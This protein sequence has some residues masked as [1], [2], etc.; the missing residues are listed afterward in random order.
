[1]QDP[2]S[3]R[4]ENVA[5]ILLFGES[6]K[7]GA[8]STRQEGVRQDPGSE[9]EN[10]VSILLFGDSTKQGATSAWQEGARQEPDTTRGQYPLAGPAE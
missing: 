10:S 5:S 9:W 8:T 6:T 7:Q 2:G 1:M 3:E 4:E